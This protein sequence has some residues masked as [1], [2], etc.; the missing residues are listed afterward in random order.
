V[1]LSII[2][3]DVGLLD[4]IDAVV[5]VKQGCPLSPLLFGL[6]IKGLEAYVK[7]R[8]PQACPLCGG[9]YMSLLMYADDTAVLVNS[10]QELQQLLHCIQQWCSEHGMTIHVDK[11]S[12]LVIFNTTASALLGLR[13]EWSIGGSHVEVSPQVKNLGIHFHFSTGAAYGVQ[14]AAQ[15][16][17]FAIACLH[18]KLHDLD[19]GANVEL[20]LHMYSS[21]VE[22]ALLY[23]CELWEQNCMQLT[24]PAG[25]NSRRGGTGSSQ[26]HSVCDEGAKEHLH[27]RIACIER[28]ECT[29]SN[30]SACI[31][32]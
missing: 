19:V 14:K 17:R 18:R 2:K 15:R 30:R 27:R 29:L 24:D 10:A 3:L 28:L 9:V 21:I 13:N 32:C 12:I 8:L 26:F 6:H 4:P 5:G 22:L 7:T 25:N 23:E 31:T 11:T 20:A 1:L 16:G